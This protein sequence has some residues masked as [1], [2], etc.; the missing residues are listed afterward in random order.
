M[1][2]NIFIMIAQLAQERIANN[3]VDTKNYLNENTHMNRVN[4]NNSICYV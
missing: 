1:P 3:R 2:I 4:I